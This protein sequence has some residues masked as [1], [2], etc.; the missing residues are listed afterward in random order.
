M[1]DMEAL[2]KKYD[3]AS[4]VFDVLI[5]GKS[6]ID[7]RQGLSYFPIRKYEDADRF[8]ECYGF[9]L[10][11]LIEKAEI[12]GNYREA[13]AFVRKYFLQPENPDGMKLEV[14]RKIQELTDIRDLFLMAN[15]S[16]PG[17]QNDPPGQAMMQW[18]CA[19]LRVVHT[20]VHIDKD[21]RAP[22]IAET[23]KQI[24]DR[25]YKFIH[26]DEKGQLYLGATDEDPMR[27]DLIA[28]ETKP[29]KPRD[30]IL[31]KLLHKPENV[32]EELFDRV[33]LRFITHSSLDSLRVVKFLK[34][35]MIIMPANIK[36]SRSRNTLANLTS[37][38]DAIQGLKQKNEVAEESWVSA[39]NEASLKT[40]IAAGINPHSSEHYRSMQFTCRQLI[41]FS[42]PLF[43]ELR[44]LKVTAKS[45]ELPETVTKQIERMD[46]KFIQ[47]QVR[48]FY[49]FEIQIVDQ[50]SHESNEK[51]RSAHSDYRKAQIQT[52]M[53]R[54]MKNFLES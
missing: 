54:V 52:A 49:P 32:A 34:D 27:V 47:K 14:P 15:F 18:A 23:Q 21:V 44:D 31:L 12:I 51:G 6:I 10:D 16:L 7:T 40:D 37:V 9:D 33:G 17:Q 46:L 50:K 35:Q 53:K 45:G 3:F 39:L 5:G 22:Y 28:F 8:I 48:F 41:R 42:N 38:N 26:R 19:L 24:F 13:L 2:S 11:D 4:E 29:K 20:I 43:N 1:K 30:S 25:F 36:P